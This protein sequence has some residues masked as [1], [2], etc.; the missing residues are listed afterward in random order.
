L[1]TLLGGYGIE[2]H[3]PWLRVGG[4]QARQQP[5]LHRGF[6]PRTWRPRNW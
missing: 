2:R 4:D 3:V 5:P 1:D 6:S